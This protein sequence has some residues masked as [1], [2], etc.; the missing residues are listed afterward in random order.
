MPSSAPIAGLEAR[1]AARFSAAVVAILVLGVV[2]FVVVDTVSA[3]L[4]LDRTLRLRAER[5]ASRLFRANGNPSLAAGARIVDTEGRVVRTGEQST[6]IRGRGP[7]EGLGYVD[8]QS[9][10]LRLYAVPLGGGQSLQVFDNARPDVLD[11]IG[12][13]LALLAIALVVGAATYF[14]GLGFAKRALAPVHETVARLERFTA[15]AGHELRTPLASARASLDV[16]EKTGNLDG[17]IQRARVEIDHASD[18]IDRLLELARL[19]S[20]ELRLERVRVSDVIARVIEEC[21]RFANER[22]VRVTTRASEGEVA[23]D[24]VLLQRLVT[25]LVVNAIQFADRGSTVSV[26][27]DGHTLEVHDFGTAIPPDDLP[28]IF[29]PFFQSEHSRSSEG[30][31]LGLA[32][33]SAISQ[34]HGWSL[35]VVSSPEKG[36]TFTVGMRPVRA[37]RRS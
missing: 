26:R 24:A 2:V 11:T 18:T 25:N 36:T 23:A 20:A 27:F 35:D 3:E 29:E 5:V 30:S 19:D 13:S 9:G 22:P 31:G 37:A 16:A 32:I 12:R 17:G 34:V 6:N 33:A 14:V 1:L 4:R 8:T 15:D 28:R 7:L 10:K 21:G